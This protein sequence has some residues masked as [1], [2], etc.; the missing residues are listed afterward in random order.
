MRMCKV[1]K[2]SKSGFYAWVNIPEAAYEP[3]LRAEIVAFQKQTHQVYGHRRLLPEMKSKGH[4]CSKNKILRILREENIRGK[5]RKIRPY[6]KAPKSEAQTIPN[7][8]SRRFE[9][10]SPNQWWV[11]DITYIWTY[12]GWAYLCVVLD[13]Y[14]RMVVGWAL[15]TNPD[16]KLTTL[17]LFRAVAL[18]RPGAGVH[19]HSDQGCQYSSK[20]YCSALERLGFKHS[21]S[22][23]GQCWDNAPMESWNSTLKRESDLVSQ[24]R[25]GIDE[26]EKALFVWIE[27]WYNLQR[28]HSKLGYCSPVSFEKK[29]AA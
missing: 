3:E 14:S 4:K 29:K 6:S 13:L 23:R 5:N 25:N 18:R 15:S 26:V 20:E 8:L 7:S 21:M 22:G 17:A 1:L 16:S 24:T 27:G 2:V 11:T 12:S 19:M 10:D 9:V 28:R